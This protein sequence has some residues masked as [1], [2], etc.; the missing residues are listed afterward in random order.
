MW[1]MWKGLR[2]SENAQE[3]CK[4]SPKINFEKKQFN[5]INIMKTYSV[6][7][8]FSNSIQ[9]NKKSCAKV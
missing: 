2:N 1:G 8:K 4:N 3:A 6:L 9:C 5:V 7:S